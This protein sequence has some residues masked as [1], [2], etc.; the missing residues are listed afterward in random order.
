V[1]WN[2]PKLCAA[3]ILQNAHALYGVWAFSGA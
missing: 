1:L 2:Y 3:L